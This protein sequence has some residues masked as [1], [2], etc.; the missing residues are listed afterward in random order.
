M[1]RR[2]VTIGAHTCDKV[3]VTR[4]SIRY[5]ERRDGVTRMRYRRL[6]S[7]SNIEKKQITKHLFLFLYCRILQNRCPTF[8]HHLFQSS[9]DIRPW[10]EKGQ[11]SESWKN[12]MTTCNY[13][14]YTPPPPGTKNLLPESPC[15][16]II[17][18]SS[19]PPFWHPWKASHMTK[20]RETPP[21]PTISWRPT[22]NT[23]EPKKSPIL[24]APGA[25]PPSH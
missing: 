4:G 5:T 23:P 20:C 15:K 10:R 8:A 13:A 16:P 2:G 11:S 12:S 6:F 7:V 17:S 25:P 1:T 22:W 3:G 24:N 19:P 14:H 18:L 9:Y 21:P